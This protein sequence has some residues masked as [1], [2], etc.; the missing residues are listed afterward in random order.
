MSASNREQLRELPLGSDVPPELL[1]RS[2]VHRLTEEVL[3]FGRKG[4]ARI[5]EFAPVKLNF[6]WITDNLAVGGAFRRGD[7][8]RMRRMGVDAIV[9]CRLEDRDDEEA[10]RRHGIELLHLP[11]P[12]THEISQEALDFGVDWARERMSQ[13][14]KVYV[15][16]LHGVGR[17]PLLGSCILVDSGHSARQALELVKARRWQASPNEEQVEA[18]VTWA[19]RHRDPVT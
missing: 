17:G 11:A 19:R 13:G 8:P 7:I 2:P 15:H 10:L 18:L 1:D 16:C 14:K 3:R 9:D 6:S 5:L 4:V 12:D